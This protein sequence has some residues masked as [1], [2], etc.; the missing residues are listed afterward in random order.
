LITATFPLI[1]AA[2]AGL[3]TESRTTTGP[4][5]G[6]VRQQIQQVWQAV[7]QKSIWL[8]VAFLFLWQATP[9]SDAAFFFFTTNELGFEPEFLGRVRLV[10]SIASLAGIWLFQRFLKAIPV[11]SIF[12]W[13]TIISAIL[14]M[15]TLLLVTHA[16]RQLGIDDRWFSLG[17][18]LILAVMGQIAY[19]PV[20]VLAARLCPRGIEAT[21][22]ALLMSISNLAGILSHEAGAVMMYLLGIKEQ[23]FQALWIL[24]VITN[25]S[26]L[27]PLPLL[28]WLPTSE[29]KRP[30][31][32]M[33]SITPAEMTSM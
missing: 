18:S 23:Q 6:V 17:D 11:R 27:L 4:D 16:N 26:T 21:V 33:A 32:E 20:L 14:G 10:T 30:T 31:P 1:I 19:M 24:V 8:P 3:I 28:R 12:L 29:V 13:S 2:V 7:R 25:L 5:L 15:T 22:F 9:S